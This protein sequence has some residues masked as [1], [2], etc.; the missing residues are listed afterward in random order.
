MN[1]SLQGF[2]L[3]NYRNLRLGSEGAFR[4]NSLNVL[5]GANGSGKSN[6]IAIIRFLKDCI[7]PRGLESGTPFMY[8]VSH[9]R[10]G[11]T[12]ILDFAIKKPSTITATYAFH[13]KT[14]DTIIALMIELSV[15]SG[16]GVTIY[17]E[18]L[19]GQNA[20]SDVS[21]YMMYTTT[22]GEGTYTVTVSK[23]KLTELK[24]DPNSSN[25][26]MEGNVQNINLEKVE[27]DQLLLF[28]IDELLENS[29]FAPENIPLYFYRR[30]ILDEVE[31]W[32]FYNANHMDLGEIRRSEPRISRQDRY[33]NEDGTNLPAV[34]YNLRNDDRYFEKRIS[35][36]MRMILPKT[37]M[38][39]HHPV[40]SQSLSIEWSFDGVDDPLI[41]SDLSD[42]T[43]RMLCW[44]VV[45]LSPKLPALL[46]IE[47]P[48]VGLHPAWMKV[49][50]TWIKSAAERTQLIVTTHSPDLLDQFTDRIEDVA[51]FE[52]VPGDDFHYTINRLDKEAL[53]QWFEREWEL[54]DMYRM[55]HPLV[56]GWP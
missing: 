30:K 33:L 23:D 52:P 18:S 12:N 53:S 44:A 46:V 31:T 37:D 8:A 19:F 13:E 29:K 48:E 34:F 39:R 21:P 24:K 4:L 42:G 40:G 10:L 54:G 22:L 41:L 28:N 1:R 17:K 50:A 26:L 25:F 9:E 15:Q 27:N 45:L 43:V 32:Q 38:I 3:L 14:T 7:M 35:E 51:V 47:E 49:L 20:Q 6:A 2:T 5:I 36:A 16:T 55:G 11:W 56:G